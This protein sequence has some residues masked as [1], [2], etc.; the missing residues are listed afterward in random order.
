MINNNVVTAPR[1][2]VISLSKISASADS[3]EKVLND[4]LAYG[5]DAT[6]FE[7][8]YGNDA[9]ARFKQENRR[10]AEFGAKH[11]T[12]TIDQF[13]ARWPNE[14]IPRN[15][16]FISVRRPF[17]DDP[18]Y[19]KALSPGTLGCFYSHYRLW[20]KCVELNEPIF[21]FEDDVIFSRGYEP[22]D[23]DDVLMVCIGKKAYQHRFYGPL[24]ADPKGTPQ[25]LTMPSSSFPGA[26]GYGIKPHAAKKLID[27]YRIEVLPADTA[28]NEFVVKLQC[29]SHIM[30]RAAIDEDGKISLTDPKDD[31]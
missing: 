17:S 10:I 24:I 3:S 6:L 1:A 31:H 19:N 26:V 9:L 23:W 8:T 12:Y 7:G 5:F 25:A 15:A 30:G 22:V 29:H 21:I 4:L 11:E 27:C 18:R 13:R 16:V 2:Y 14:P 28:I 20:Q